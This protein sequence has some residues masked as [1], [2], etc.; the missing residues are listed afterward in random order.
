VVLERIVRELNGEPCLN[1]SEVGPK[2]SITNSRSF[3]EPVESFADLYE[4][5]YNYCVKVV[6]RLKAKNIKIYIRKINLIK[7]V[8][9]VVQD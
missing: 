9:C 3:S 6:Y 1:I 4:A 2:K 7:A 5:L 8:N